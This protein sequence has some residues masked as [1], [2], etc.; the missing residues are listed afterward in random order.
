MLRRIV[1]SRILGPKLM[2]ATMNIADVFPPK[3]QVQHLYC[4]DYSEALDLAYTDFHEDVLGVDIT[5]RRSIWPT[6]GRR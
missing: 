5:I 3:D 6:T 1:W 4:S 2:G